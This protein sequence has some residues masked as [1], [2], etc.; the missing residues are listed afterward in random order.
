MSRLKS[1]K[2]SWPIIAP[3]VAPLDR[4][5]AVAEQAPQAGAAEQLA[6]AVLARQ[7]LAAE[8]AHDLGIAH[9]RRLGVDV[10]GAERPEDEARGLQRPGAARAGHLISCRG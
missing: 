6:P 5:I 9:H 8:M 3:V 2:P 1:A 7:R 4:P 10:V